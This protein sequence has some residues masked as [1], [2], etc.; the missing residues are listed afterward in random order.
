MIKK[1][2]LLMLAVLCG[3]ALRAQNK[4]LDHDVYDGWQSVT[5]VQ[6]SPDGRLL[7]YEIRPQE[8]DA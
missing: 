8:G 5:A 1:V 4:P 6:L 7:S 2:F 3:A